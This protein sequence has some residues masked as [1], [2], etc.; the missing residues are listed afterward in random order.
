MSFHVW[1][2]AG[3]G[4][5]LL[6]IIPPK[7]SVSAHAGENVHASRGKI[8]GKLTADGWVGLADWTL[9]RA[10]DDMRRR[11]ARWNASIGL[12]TRSFP[13]VDIDISD[14]QLANT[15]AG[16]AVAYLGGAAVRRRAGSSRMVL[17]FRT[18]TP[19]PKV[20][21]TLR[22]LIGDDGKPCAVEILGDGQQIVV[23][24]THPSGSPYEWAR[25]PIAADLTPIT[26]AEVETFLAKLTSLLDLLGYEPSRGVAVARSLAGAPEA[27]A[28]LAPSVAAVVDALSHV[29]N[30]VDY[31][32]W[33]KVAVAVKA[34][35]GEEGFEPFLEWSLQ[36]PANT[37]EIVEAKWDSL[38][39]PY[40]LGWAW[41]SAWARKAGGFEPLHHIFQPVEEAP[42]AAEKVIDVE[43]SPSNLQGL[44]DRYVWV[45]ELKRAFDV[46]T[47]QLLDR[48][49]FNIANNHVG[50]ASDSKHCAWARWTDNALLLKR[51]RSITYVPGAGVLVDGLANMWTA[52]DPLPDTDMSVDP[53][54]N[55][56]A[57]IYPEDE[58]RELLFDWLAFL[59]QRQREKPRFALV[60]GSTHEGVGKD[61][62]LQPLY[63]ALGR[64]NVGTVSADQVLG[65][66]TDWVENRRLIVVQE[67][68]TYGKRETANRL[69]IYLASPPEQVPIRKV[70]LPKYEIPNTFAILF[71]TNNASAVPIAKEDRRYFVMWS[72]HPPAPAA[73]YEAL[74]DWYA[75]GGDVA[76]ARWLLERDI[77]RFLKLTTAPMTAAKKD[78]QA[79]GLSPLEAWIEEGVAEGGGAFAPDLVAPDDLCRRVP[80]SAKW[81]QATPARMASQLRR[82]GA[83]PLHRVLLPAALPTGV[84]RVTIYS[85]RRHEMYAGL[86]PDKITEMFLK[87]RAEAE[88][89]N[90]AA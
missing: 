1:A 29:P 48:E 6:P 84:R 72:E 13:A 20:R 23:E 64:Q 74:A 2:E 32:T 69:K 9:L 83:R 27:D 67:M 56:V 88:A 76:V 31:D 30:D 5:D 8:P 81:D 46:E 65:P 16:M 12:Q 3:F 55:H 42:P 17:L 43:W 82:A 19:M 34:A 35:A 78:M 87:Q 22:G 18:D 47:R 45:E 51:V 70:Y 21:I 66:Y 53:W 40:R 86:P 24:G 39:P 80:T 90:A 36:W 57:M 15:V 68:A 61:M 62:M 79:A 58:E 52:P 26:P 37:P 44:F 73:H 49:Q 41:L 10:N 33:V 60:L 28:L 11:W 75:A 59:L 38:R 7:A 77:S 25:Q 4:P 89:L 50:R 54:L 85:V 63:R 14:P 71:L